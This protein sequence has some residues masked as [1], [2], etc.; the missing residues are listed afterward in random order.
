MM[1]DNPLDGLPAELRTRVDAAINSGSDKGGKLRDDLTLTIETCDEW[2]KNYPKDTP[3]YITR[4]KLRN[5]SEF[6]RD[7]IKDLRR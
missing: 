1:P 3:E 6:A 5:A 2:A 4:L 7:L